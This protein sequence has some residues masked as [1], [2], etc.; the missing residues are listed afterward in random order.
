VGSQA[1]LHGTPYAVLVSRCFPRES[2]SRAVLDDIV[3]VE[4]ARCVAFAEIMRRMGIETYRSSVVGTSQ[5]EKTAELFQFISSTQ[6]RQSIP[7]RR[8]SIRSRN[9]WVANEKPPEEVD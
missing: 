8:Q 4:P 2:T 7:C 9:C 5:A 1:K 6:F 3:V